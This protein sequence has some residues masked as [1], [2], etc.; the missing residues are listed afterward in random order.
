MSSNMLTTYNGWPE[1]GL[2]RDHAT[3][4]KS[5]ELINNLLEIGIK[6]SSHG[7]QFQY[8]QTVFYTTEI[9]TTESKAAAMRDAKNALTHE[10]YNNA[11]PRT[12]ARLEEQVRVA[13]KDYEF[14][15]AKVGHELEYLQTMNEVSCDGFAAK[16]PPPTAMLSVRPSGLVLTDDEGDTMKIISK[17]KWSANI[18]KLKVCITPTSFKKSQRNTKQEANVNVC[19]DSWY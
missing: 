12:I 9:Y 11:N 15:S 19:I 7:K 2:E 18:Y 5:I 10:I 3:A 8:G 14:Y 4:E 17:M 16:L 6:V 1:Y 13:Q